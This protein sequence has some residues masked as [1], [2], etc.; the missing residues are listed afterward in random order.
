MPT[1]SPFRTGQSEKVSEDIIVSVERAFR[2]VEIM[3]DSTVGLGISEVARQLGVNKAI[4]VKLL[5]TLSH[6]ELVW[7]D[8]VSQ[9]YQLT[10]RISNLGLRQLQKS[11]LLDQSAVP[12]K[13]L[14]EHSGELVRL[15]IVETTER[16][17]WIYAVAGQTR[18]VRIDPNY[19]LEIVLNA[20][21]I[22]KAWLS[23]MPF[24]RAWGL[25]ER[26]GLTRLTPH[27]K[28]TRTDLKADLDLSRTRG[29]A[30]AYEEQELGVGAIAAPI[31][32]PSLDGSPECVGAVSLAA[33]TN[34]MTREALE[35]FAP[36]LIE[37]TE[38]LGRIWPLERRS[39]RPAW[40]K[41]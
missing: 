9:T 41:I 2:I 15:A 25:L 20:H 23:T 31:V 33:P 29:F 36:V 26:Q 21:A 32:I 4:A 37:T 11:R 12:L 30:T 6:L 24:E 28:I 40:R 34:R 8:E 3:A 17:T 35:A 5:D 14:A 18:S 13:Q 19:S 22:G 7:R 38:K 27:T 16:L 1:A 10:Y 39:L